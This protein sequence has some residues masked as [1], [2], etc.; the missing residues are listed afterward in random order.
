MKK[1]QEKGSR[2]AKARPE[3]H[4]RL[5][6]PPGGPW[7]HSANAK[8]EW[9]DLREHLKAVAQLARGFAEPFGA[10]D[11]AYLA[12]LWHDLGK[13]SPTFQEYLAAASSGDWH[14]GELRG[15]VDHTSAGAQ[16]AVAN[17]PVLGHLLAFAVAGHHA[18]LL[19]AISDGACLD[20]RLR[21]E[22]PQWS[23][24]L[25]PAPDKPQAELSAHLKE[26]LACRGSD[27]ESAAFSFALFTRMLFSCLVDADFL[28]TEAFLDHDRAAFRPN[29]P[30]AILG[31][32]EDALDR[33]MA[34]W[35][36]PGSPVDSLRRQVRTACQAGAECEPGF[37]SLTVPTGGGK[38]LSSLAFAL[39]HARRFD[40]RRVVYVVPFTTI[41]EQ[42]AD[43]FRQVFAGL[44]E[45]GL[46]DPVVEHHSALDVGEETVASRLASENWDAPLVVT[47][48][49]Q[50]YESLFACQASRCRKLH[51]LANAVII[52]DEVQKIPVDYLR[53]CLAALAE[54]VSGYG[55]SVVLCTATQPAIQRREEFPIGIAGVREIVPDPQALHVAMKRVEARDEGLIDDE[56]LAARLRAE[57]QV[58]CIV[59]TRRHARE[60][61]ARLSSE[62]GAIHLSAAMCPEH[63]SGVLD[64]VR[65]RLAERQPCLVVSTQLVEAGVDLDFPVVYRSLAGLDSI[66][67]AAGRCNRN[68]RLASGVVHLFRSEHGKSE[69]FLRD[70]TNAATQLLGGGALP[71]LHQ[72]ILSLEAVEH[73]FRL[74]YWD[75]ESRWDAHRIFDELKLENRRE[76]PF[77]FGFRSISESF[78]LIQQIGRPVIVPWREQGKALCQEL[79]NPWKPPDMLLLRKLQRYTVEAPRRVWEAEQGRSLEIVRDRFAILV[80]PEVHYDERLGLI[81]DRQDMAAETLIT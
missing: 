54:L 29:W 34:T 38:T 45:C 41:I 25:E 48:S 70:T 39:R 68:G 42:N 64:G 55:S 69:A 31:S 50:F 23:R 27:P 1:P 21:K 62:E 74:Y 67:Q 58:L 57:G 13:A 24:Y 73:Y 66:A 17:V 49:V 61:F 7:A 52:L 8:G 46:P 35:S 16:Y 72:D 63:R 40:L 15:S 28:D 26:R 30:P 22:V 9:H 81:L 19:D 2:E 44:V 56:D 20:H 47:T 5:N 53:P 77:L 33:F 59:N 76:L 65:G 6:P 12:G 37:F 75:Q 4:G 80:S 10:G 79:R 51:N 78:H 60:L 71:P 14:Q 3:E 36:A 43:V 11:W 18:G 32:M